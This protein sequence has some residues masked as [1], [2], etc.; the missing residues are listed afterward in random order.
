MVQLAS[1]TAPGIPDASA[2]AR[3]R[4]AAED[5]VAQQQRA[6]VGDAAAIGSFSG[7]DRQAGDMHIRVGNDLEDLSNTLSTDGE[8]AGARAD[9]GHTLT[10]AD[11]QGSV[12]LDVVHAGVELNGS[13]RGVGVGLS[14][15][16]S[17]GASPLVLAAGDR[18][19]FRGL[20][21]C[22]RCR[23]RRCLGRR[24]ADDGKLAVEIVLEAYAI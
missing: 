18:E 22:R 13:L 12:E 23:R 17:Q 24:T 7:L 16:V 3:G 11:L 20:G 6:A 15:R 21:R 2:V 8:L 14:N 4:V 5:V 9:D 1:V 19:R 10:G